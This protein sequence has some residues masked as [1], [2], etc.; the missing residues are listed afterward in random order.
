[1]SQ[2]MDMKHEEDIE[3]AIALL[4]AFWME[5]SEGMVSLWSILDQASNLY[6]SSTDVSN[7]EIH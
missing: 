7:R 4:I 3:T 2:A 1:M 6:L 5:H